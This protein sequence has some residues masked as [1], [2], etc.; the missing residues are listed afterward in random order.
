M[1]VFIVD[2]VKVNL[3]LLEATLKGADYDVVSATNG[4]EALG[5][6]STE[7]FDI[8]NNTD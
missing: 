2:D 8:T 4:V 7:G 3:R 6:L 1:K 5:K